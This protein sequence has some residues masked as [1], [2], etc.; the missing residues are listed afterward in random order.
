MRFRMNR[1]AWIADIEK[2]FLNIA[3]QPEDSEAIRFLWPEELSKIGFPL[4][5]YKWKRVPFGLSSSPFLLRA[6]INK[7]LESVQSRYPETVNQLIEQLC[8]RLSRWYRRCR[9]S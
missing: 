9:V 1:C 8:R 6:T 4:I 7:H 5:A 3:L 2:A